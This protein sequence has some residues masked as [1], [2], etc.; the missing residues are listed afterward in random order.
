MRERWAL[1]GLGVAMLAIAAVYLVERPA[2]E[3]PP[4]PDDPI[5]L[6]RRLRMH[7][8][9]WRAASA[10][11]EHALDAP[12][13]NRFALW[14]AAHDIAQ[15]LAPHRDAPRM[16]LVR[17]AFFHWQELDPADRRAALDQLAPLLRDRSNFLK[18]ALP[19]YELTGDLG[20]L[21]RWN[22]G[23]VEALELLRNLAAANGRFD[24]YRELRDEVRRKRDANF[25]QKLPRLSPVEIIGALPPAPYSTDDEPLL[26]DALAELHRRPLTDDPH[27]INELDALV[28]YALRHRLEPLDGINS[29]V[30]MHGAASDITRYRLAQKFGMNAAAFDIR[31]AAKTPLAEP[32]GTWQH[33]LDDGTVNGRAW[34]DREMTGLSSIVIQTIKSDEVPP[35]VEIYLDDARVAEGEVA[36]SRSFAIPATKGMHRLEVRV[37]NP[38][39]R[40][41]APRIVRVVSLTP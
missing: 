5:A 20:M 8:A 26:R 10:L 28:D 9:D 27:R 15:T 22:P 31:L 32:R 11:T 36:T 35:W 1:A 37:V 39:T 4:L 21:R 19:V 41:L 14:H 38:Q 24:D 40:N 25:H 6:A 13:A 30:L 7:P 34:I 3:P 23:S 2:S 12:V 16:E 33:L 18:M 17:A 29:I